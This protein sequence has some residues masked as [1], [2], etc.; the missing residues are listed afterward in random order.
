MLITPAHKKAVLI[1]ALT[2]IAVPCLLEAVGYCLDAINV[3]PGN[4]LSD[5]AICV[6][7]AGLALMDTSDNLE[8]YVVFVIA[9]IAN[10]ILYAFIVF[11]IGFL[12]SPD[13]RPE[14]WW[15]TDR[16]T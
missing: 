15:P 10:G 16:N 1:S 2:G 11:V 14:G 5:V 12:M 13:R 3:H 6:W 9:A 8:G 4:W 7:P